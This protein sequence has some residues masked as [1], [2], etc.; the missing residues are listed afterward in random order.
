MK[1]PQMTRKQS[2]KPNKRHRD[3][4]ADAAALSVTRQHLLAVLTYRR[5]SKPLLKRYRELQRRKR[6]P[7]QLEAAA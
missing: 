1:Y 6:A 7:R 4:V 5:D 3:I 2:R